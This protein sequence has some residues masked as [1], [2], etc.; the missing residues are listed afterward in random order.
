LNKVRVE[1]EQQQNAFKEIYS[2]NNVM[3]NQLNREKD[4]ME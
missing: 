1:K 3:I 4:D 2:E